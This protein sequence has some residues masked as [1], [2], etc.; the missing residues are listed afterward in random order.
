MGLRISVNEWMPRGPAD[1][2][3]ST[4]G[5]GGRLG[6]GHGG[7]G[8]RGGFF[9]GQGPSPPRESWPGDCRE[10]GRR[11]AKRHGRNESA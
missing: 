8:G 10:R 11:R 2:F 6:G 3:S 1:V 4:A 9:R 5:N 7:R